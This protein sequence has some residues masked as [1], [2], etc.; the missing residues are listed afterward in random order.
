MITYLINAFN[1]FFIEKNE[2]IIYN[3]NNDKTNINLFKKPD[4]YKN[5]NSSQFII[6]KIN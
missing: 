6:K 3:K 4:V 2:N 5:I 1:G